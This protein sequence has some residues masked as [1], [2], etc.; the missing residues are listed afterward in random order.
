MYLSYLIFLGLRKNFH[1][2]MVGG[3]DDENGT[4]SKLSLELLRCFQ[5]PNLH[6][7][8]SVD[9]FNFR[10]AT[11]VNIDFYELTRD[12]HFGS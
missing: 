11:T 10:N 3:Y 9:F 7:G 6:I 1:L 12:R 4:S 2:F 8:M 5:T